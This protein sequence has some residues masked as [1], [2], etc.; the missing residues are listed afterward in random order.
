M[1]IFTIGH[2]MHTKDEFLHMLHH[3]GVDTLVDVRTFPASRKYP[4]FKKENMEKWLPQSGV[5]Y[6]HLP[7]LGGR[8]PRS[9]YIQDELNNAWQNQSFHNYADYTLSTDFQEGIDELKNLA[10]KNQVAYCCAERHPSRCH[11][12]LISNWLTANDWKV[13]HIIDIKDD[14]VEMIIHE[15]GR[16]GA[17]PI[18]ESDG[19]VVYPKY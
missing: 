14:N 4:H 8:R 9:P 1:T 17:M 16:W 7:L 10:T 5:D 19:T 3:A 2:S 6:Q 12:L 18:I 13:K 11:R 15:L